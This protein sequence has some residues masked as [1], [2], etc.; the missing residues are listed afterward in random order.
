MSARR[1]PTST[2][3][4]AALA[5]CLA[6]LG[7][8]AT[9]AS[10]RWNRISHRRSSTQPYFACA[11][12]RL[13]RCHLIVDPTR[14]LHRNGPVSAGAITAGPELE[15]S[16]ALGGNGVEG[17][18]SPEN[19]RS[20][21][22][23]PSK[24]AGSGQ[25]VAIVDAYD[26]PNAEADLSTYRSHYGI[27]SCT[28]AGGCFRKVNEEGG[29]ARPATNA[30]WSE[31]IS[32][33]LDMVSAVCPNCHIL[34]VEA[35]T[36]GAEDLATAENEA[37]ALGATEVSNSFGSPVGQ[38]LPFVSA[39]DHP[40][41]PTTVAA[42]D[43]GY[44]VEV[45]ADNPHVIAVGG[46]TLVPE[47]N[48]RGWRETVWYDVEEA[49]ISG[50]G[51][52]CSSEPKPAW[53][54]DKGC[55]GRTN[56]D[57][58]AIGDQNTPVS[59]Y[60]SYKSA[61]PW[62]LEGGTSVGAPIVAAAMAL[63]NSY[64]RTFDGAHALYV[65]F[66]INPSGFFNDVVSGKNGTC[67]GSYLC[68]ARVGYDGPSGLGTL[69]G[70]PEVPPPTL[71]TEPASSIGSSEATLNAS[72]DPNGAEI[73]QCRFEYGPSSSYTGS[74]PCAS[75]PG[76]GVNPVSLVAHVS[77]LH[78]ASVYHFRVSVAYQ[79][80]QSSAGADRTFTTSGAAPPT[81]IT[82][83][84]SAIGQSSATL[85]AKVD[86]NGLTV[87]SCVLEY[88]LSSSYEKTA[89]CTPS[90]GSGQTYVNVS[91]AVGGLSAKTTYH[92]RVSATNS[93]G[94]THG[95]DQ[96]F[97]TAPKVPIVEPEAASAVTQT[98]AQLNASVNPSGSLVK[99]CRF[100]YGASESYGASVPCTPSPGSGAGFVAVSGEISG[101][102]ANT[103]YH[104]RVV[105]TNSEGTTQTVDETFTSAPL[106]PSGETEGYFAL[107]EGSVTVQGTVHPNGGTLTECRF[108]YG[109]S[110]TGILEASAP[111]TTLPGGEEEGASVLAHISG[112]N[113][114]VTYRYRL[115]T[116]NVSGTSYGT[117]QSF[118]TL[119]A[120]LQ[121][122]PELQKLTGNPGPTPLP[123]APK[124]VSTAL[125]ASSG[126]LVIRVSCAAG[127]SSCTGKITL[128]AVAAHSASGKGH[129]VKHT[130]LLAAG[131]IALAGGRVATLRLK[132]SS[133]AKALLKRSHV[134]HARATITS[135]AGGGE[136]SR[137][138]VT[139]RTAGH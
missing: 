39:Y 124:L 75:S 54:F 60:D 105:A 42:G 132:L 70:A 78:S 71:T 95:S 72:V 120:H 56:D 139:I 36:A 122:E 87:T 127:A 21:Y 41:I 17:G 13:S 6:L 1:C 91:A 86:P 40:G 12:K 138:A 129:A 48:K 11:S 44:G 66:A 121:S 126:S 22:D 20:A 61:N 112:L 99:T 89:P 118:T 82:E 15:T 108:E 133:S 111:C 84:A 74:V 136:A 14:G 98:G 65:D 63:T 88:G 3:C 114:A 46:T 23:L 110:P 27:S 107:T 102:D 47:S 79:G 134:L 68:E 58:A 51:S 29:S 59:V 50:T 90:P 137:L 5:V 131:S 4:V 26:D 24:T 55:S 53:Q 25:T 116:A 30:E 83:A 113:P 37:V 119:V 62:M 31:E 10:A 81:S 73:S 67:G 109:T 49:E 80:G 43:E 101:L 32:L 106:A 135:G 104:F 97:K 93:Q 19:L 16:P 38:E 7:A 96:T 35:D 64:T 123:G 117:T 52:G 115:V 9:S 33:D 85:N 125:A 28:S 130:V 18:Y 34:L 128:Q 69:K 8:T 45:P 92:F 94:T 103:V 76:S 100:E 2:C 57:V 77:G